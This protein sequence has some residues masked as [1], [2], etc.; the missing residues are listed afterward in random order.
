MDSKERTKGRGK[1]KGADSGFPFEDCEAM[2]ERMKGCCGDMADVIDCCSMM[3]K[4]KD[5]TSDKSKK[6]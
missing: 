6:E 3:G 4:M 1:S 2:I 5:E